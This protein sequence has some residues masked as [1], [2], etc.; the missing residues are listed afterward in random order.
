[1]A[2]T[3]LVALIESFSFNLYL[4]YVRVQ[5][6]QLDFLKKVKD[7]SPLIQ[8]ASSVRYAEWEHIP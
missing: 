7:A 1:M 8:K 6:R 4:Q 3:Y 2:L 5:Q